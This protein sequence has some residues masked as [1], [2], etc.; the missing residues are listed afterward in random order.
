MP[1]PREDPREQ[2][3]ERGGRDAPASRPRRRRRRG[4]SSRRMM[5]GSA[6]PTVRRPADGE[7]FENPIVVEHDVG[8]RLDVRRRS[9]CA[10]ILARASSADIPR[11]TRRARRTSGD[12]RRPRRTASP[13]RR[14]S[15]PAAGSPGRPHR[16]VPVCSATV[17]A[18][19]VPDLRVDD[20]LERSTSLVVG[21]HERGERRAVELA[22]GLDHDLAEKPPP[23]ASNPGVPS[24]TASRARPRRASR[25]RR[26]GRRACAPRCSCP[27]RSRR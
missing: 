3:G 17:R 12:A 15:R 2:L 21:E 14:P 26:R 7:L 1:L 13:D 11:A 23:R 22:V 24:A 16:S 9:I 4:T 8:G 20:G 5:A 18:I 19:R 6:R 25:T 27:L 10:A